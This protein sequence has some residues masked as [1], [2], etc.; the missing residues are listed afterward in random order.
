MKNLR[1]ARRRGYERSG[2]LPGMRRYHKP[3]RSQILKKTASAAFI[4]W[5]LN[6]GFQGCNLY[7]SDA[8]QAR[9]EV[10]TNGAWLARELKND[11]TFNQI[12]SGYVASRS[13]VDPEMGERLQA[14]RENAEKL[15]S[16]QAEFEKRIEKIYNPFALIY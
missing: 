8:F 2:R 14:Y 1:E 15:D 3:K 5:G 10:V 4:L 7:Y 12:V 9:K 6:A 16:T 11:E 13:V